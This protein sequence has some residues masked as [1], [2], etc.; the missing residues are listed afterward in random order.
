MLTLWKLGYGLPDWDDRWMIS[1]LKGEPCGAVEVL[2]N[3][4]VFDDGIEGSEILKKA[5]EY[6]PKKYLMPI[7]P[8]GRGNFYNEGNI[9]YVSAVNSAFLDLG[10]KD[11]G[12]AHPEHVWASLRGDV[13]FDPRWINGDF[14]IVIYDDCRYNGKH[15]AHLLEQIEERFGMPRFPAV[16][17]FAARLR[18]SRDSSFDYG[19]RLDIAENSVV[20]EAPVLDKFVS[21]NGLMANSQKIRIELSENCVL[22]SPSLENCIM[23][24]KFQKFSGMLKRGHRK[25][26]N[27]I[28]ETNRFGLRTVHIYGTRA[29]SSRQ[30][31]RIDEPMFTTQI[32]ELDWFFWPARILLSA[33]GSY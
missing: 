15:A 12:V 23:T 2:S 17:V 10:I 6:L 32:H 11:M 27:V 29:R 28:V 9:L 25:R 21:A 8:L 33:E 19:V 22:N 26:G 7:C 14:G 13:F 18:A 16:P 1:N 24:D 4:P 5:R 3:R 30:G 31:A 20:L